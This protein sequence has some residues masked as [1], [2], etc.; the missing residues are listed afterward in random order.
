M[1][2]DL[3]KVLHALSSVSVCDKNDLYSFAWI[4]GGINHQ[5]S[6]LPLTFGNRTMSSPRSSIC[7]RDCRSIVMKLQG[8]TPPVD[9]SKQVKHRPHPTFTSSLPSLFKR[10]SSQLLLH[11]TSPINF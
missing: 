7:L 2:K 9:V 8:H 11:H 1:M 4:D 5:C 3:G 10:H 6:S